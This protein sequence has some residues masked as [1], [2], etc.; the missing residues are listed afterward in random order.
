[1]LEVDERLPEPLVDLVIGLPCA[2]SGD[3]ARMEAFRGLPCRQW[4][5]SDP[6]L[7]VPLPL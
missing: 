2:G 4:P 3:P 6:N 5:E 7:G 1:M